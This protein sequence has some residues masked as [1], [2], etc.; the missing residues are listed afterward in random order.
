MPRIGI[1]GHSNLTHATESGVRGASESAAEHSERINRVSFLFLARGADQ[2][3]ARSYG[4][5]GARF[6]LSCPLLTIE[7]RSNL[8]TSTVMTRC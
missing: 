7:R 3:F 1:T 5:S 2:L 4:T 6:R 8:T